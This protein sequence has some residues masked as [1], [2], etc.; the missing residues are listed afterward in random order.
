MRRR[1][2]LA[3]TTAV[4]ALSQRLTG[5]ARAEE[6]P[7]LPA[8]LKLLELALADDA[9]GLIAPGAKLEKLW[10]KGEFTEGGAAAADGCIYF[11]DIGNEL[12]KFDPKTGQTSEYR[13]PSG[14]SNGMIFDAKGRLIVAEGANTGGQRRVTATNLKTGKIEILAD[15]YQ[16]KKF[17]SPNDV[18]VDTA[19]RVYFTDPRYVG[20]EPRELD[21]EGVFRI[22]PDGAVTRLATGAMRPNGIVVSP[23]GK[24]LYIAENSKKPV[25]LAC[26]LDDKG[27]T[28]LGRVFYEY[29]DGRGTDGMTV[30]TDGRIVA[31]AGRGEKSGV[32][33][34][35][36]EGKML[37]IIRTPETAANCEFG[38]PQ[39]KTLYICAG[40]SLYRIETTM[41]GFRL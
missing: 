15:H 28:T 13:N 2:F 1:Q 14:R 34:F 25:L 27:N 36:P 37:G 31:T 20:K 33:V 9:N 5:W 8:E 3:Q 19:G 40:V 17:N 4:L 35:S 30:T 29:T 18:A 32:W 38:G 11:S 41:T 6:T 10:D 23:D 21:F 24:T 12:M 16:G 7:I 39:G 22:D 26:P